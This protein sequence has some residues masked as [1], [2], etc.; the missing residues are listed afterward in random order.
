MIGVVDSKL[1]VLAAARMTGDT[2]QTV[3][4]AIKG[5]VAT[6]FLDKQNISYSTTSS[7][8]EL[9]VPDVVERAKA[10]TVALECKPNVAQ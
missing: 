3:N 1:N 5:T 6:R 7:E 2:A 10:F 4:F 9:T 8:I